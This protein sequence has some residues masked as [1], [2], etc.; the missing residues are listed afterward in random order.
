MNKLSVFAMKIIRRLFNGISNWYR[1]T[2]FVSGL[3]EYEEGINI[4]GPVYLWNDNYPLDLE[5]MCIKV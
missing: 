3:K 4:K 1:Y 2:S 5:P